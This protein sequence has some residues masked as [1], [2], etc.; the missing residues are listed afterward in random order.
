M[1]K[2]DI[3]L[4]I[5][6]L[7]L[8]M[9][10]LV[11]CSLTFQDANAIP[12]S[13]QSREQALVLN[14]WYDAESDRYYLYLPGFLSQEDL[15]ISHPWYTQAT[16]RAGETEH[17][18]LASIPLGQDAILTV[19][20]F[21]LEKREYTLQLL[22]C[23]SA[24]TICIEAQ[25][26]ILDYLHASQE[27]T[28]EVFVTLLD[29]D[30][31]IEYRGTSILSGRGNS[32]W[33][34]EKKPYDLKFPEAVTVGPFQD[35][36]KLCLLAE[37]YD[38]TK[39]RNA[40]AYHTAQEL[41]FPYASPYAYA[42]LFLN[43]EYL[44]LYGLATKQ[45]Y[46]KH[47]ASDGIQAVFELSITE[48]GQKFYT[49][50]HKGIRIHYGEL[51]HIQY[52]LEGMEQALENRDFDQLRQYID[53][54]SWAEKFAMEEFFYNYDSSKTSQ[55]FYLNQDGLI[56]CMLPWD[57]EWIL[58]PRLYPSDM[59]QEYALCA[60]WNQGNWYQSLLELAPFR[61]AVADA[62]R[63][64]YT[65]EFLDGLEQYM[66]DCTAEIQGSWYCDQRR[67]SS[68]YLESH[69]YTM[70]GQHMP[71]FGSDFRA[72]LSG[73]IAFLTELFHNWQDYC[74]ISFWSEQDGVVSEAKVQIILP[75]GCDLTSQYAR[76]FNSIHTPAGYIC[77]GLFASDGRP[78]EAISTLT[79][80]L[81]LTI[82]YSP[83]STETEMYHE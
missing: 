5:L 72:R 19:S 23:S 68:A 17:N 80:N 36:S 75:R 9:L 25:D 48:K 6:I 60:Y 3:S 16:I 11:V 74:R 27:H 58:Y 28:Q 73:R 41:D 12:V 71:M 4:L 70:A 59:A 10:F 81:D 49:D 22:Q 82:R 54:K 57:Y 14:P 44:G 40:L 79:D 29:K 55:Y 1:R 37:Y 21:W 45:E 43:G 76:I 35:I 39:L 32:T 15:T 13:F 33:D 51:E 65:P 78:L 69:Q 26:G 2:K 8:V 64:T 50:G 66:A 83:I 20:S 34:W 63:E 31:H 77:E 38:M 18:S 67:W 52:A 30:G 56:R 53:V 61:E 24:Q 7:F 47:I 46:Q 62:L 42:D